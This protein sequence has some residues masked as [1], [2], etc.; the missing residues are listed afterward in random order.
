MSKHNIDTE[1]VIT[2]VRIRPP[3]WDLSHDLFKDK[4][5]KLQA[6]FGVYKALLPDFNDLSENDKKDFEKSV[7]QRWRTARDAYMRCKNS[8]KSVKSGSEGGKR[9]KYV[10]F[11]HLQFLD[12]KHV[13]D[14]EDSIQENETREDTQQ[15]SNLESPINPRSTETVSTNPETQPQCSSQVRQDSSNTTKPSSS[16]PNTNPSRKRKNAKTNEDSYFDKNI[17]EFLTK[18]SEIIQNDDMAFF[19]SLLP[20]TRTFDNRQKVMFRT[21][22]MNKALEICN[23][24]SSITPLASPMYA[25]TS[26]PESSTSSMNIASPESLPSGSQDIVLYS[27]EEPSSQN[28]VRTNPNIA[29]TS[30]NSVIISLS[31]SSFNI[32]SPGSRD[33]VLYS[34]EEPSFQNV[35]TTNRNFAYTST[36]QNLENPSSDLSQYI[37]FKQ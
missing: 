16:T 5:A 31:A 32:P 12:K 33:I 36:S 30:Q 23:C 27:V 4:D 2:E 28:V 35:V 8:M 3:L 26:R 13:A 10:F 29:H 14:T 7:Q 9:T 11:K 15:D 37:N 25:S 1:R 20:L 24:P 6:W 18:N 19:Y 22:V 21:A 17:L 34:V